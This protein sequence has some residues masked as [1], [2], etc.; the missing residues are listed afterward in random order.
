MLGQLSN[1]L[2]QALVKAGLGCPACSN[3]LGDVTDVPEGTNLDPN[4]ASVL[5][6]MNQQNARMFA[7]S[8][9]T[10]TLIG[11]SALVSIVR[12]TKAIKREETAFKKL[13]V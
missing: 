7:L 13:G 2:N 8:L 3:G 11:L 6:A 9:I 1:E 4:V 10:T 5:H 12:N